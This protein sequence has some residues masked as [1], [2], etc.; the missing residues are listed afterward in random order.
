MLF[1]SPLTPNPK[2]QAPNPFLLTDSK[3]NYVFILIQNYVLYPQF[4]V[5]MYS[6]IKSLEALKELLDK[7]EC[8]II[9]FHT[10]WCPPCK[11]SEEDFKKLAS[12]YSNIKFARI[13]VDEV[14]D[15]S[16]KYNLKC[17]PTYICFKKGQNIDCL[18]GVNHE[19][20]EKKAKKM[21]NSY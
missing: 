15:V 12:K 11:N 1:R 20:L 9:D 3:Q 6:E 19:E 17:L 5:I 16:K 8:V 13:D 18:E 2:P 4:S 7:N 10:I 14:S 21:L